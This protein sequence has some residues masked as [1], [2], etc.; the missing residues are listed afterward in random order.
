MSIKLVVWDWNGTL[1][2]DAQAVLKAANASEVPMLGLPPVTLEQMRDS[3]E[4]PIIKAYENLGV[5]P[6]VFKAKSAEISPMFHR[7]Y[8]PL[9][10][11]GRTRLGARKVLDTLK[12]NHIT[13]I[14]L[15]N[16]TMEGIYFQLTRLKLMSYFGGVLANDDSTTAHHT[17]KQ[18][19]LE[20]YL[21][22]NHYQPHDVVIVGDTPEEV[23]IA[24]ALGI[25]VV[26]VSGGMCSR[27]R[28]IAAQP[29]YLV[30]SVKEIITTLEGIA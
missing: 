4:V 23:K 15:S 26:S 14:I 21:E 30:S 1:F 24:R 17:G 13:S 29:D 22:K 25:H 7:A 10:A 9:A 8:E 5:D 18:H 20:T 11:T 19:R 2:D 6:E 12:K 28:L 27:A 16:H 3:Y